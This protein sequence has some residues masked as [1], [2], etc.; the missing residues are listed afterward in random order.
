MTI[1]ESSN[2]ERTLMDRVENV[3]D[4]KDEFHLDPKADWNDECAKADDVS[5]RDISA[6]VGD[7]LFK[8]IGNI[9]AS[10]TVE[11]PTLA[12]EAKVEEQQSEARSDEQVEQTI[13]VGQQRNLSDKEI[14]SLGDRLASVERKQAEPELFDTEVRKLLASDVNASD[15]I[16]RVRKLLKNRHRREV[17]RQSKEKAESE[18]SLVVSNV[19]IMADGSKRIDIP[20][21]IPASPEPYV[22]VKEQPVDKAPVAS[23]SKFEVSKDEV[24]KAWTPVVTPPAKQKQTEQAVRL[25]KGKGKPVRQP[26][27]GVILTHEAEDHRDNVHFIQHKIGELSAL[28]R[29]LSV[30]P[31]E[32]NWTGMKME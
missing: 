28:M 18:A 17:L 7:Q 22:I 8:Q 16:R 12:E 26:S 1:A 30:V 32:L 24:I 20:S 11:Y 19:H 2:P 21:S 10:Q 15:A 23:S 25:D 4:A 5:E 9:V 14:V 31:N 13:P 27:G 6:K 29:M 3:N